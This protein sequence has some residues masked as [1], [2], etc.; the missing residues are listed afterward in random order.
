VSAG[1]AVYEDGQP[2]GAYASGAG[3]PND[4][5]VQVGMIYD[6]G[7]GSESLQMEMDNIVVRGH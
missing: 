7:G 6:V 1:I 5:K 2:V 3:A 4:T